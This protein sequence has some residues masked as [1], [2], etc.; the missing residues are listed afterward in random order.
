MFAAAAAE[1]DAD[2]EPFLVGSHG[3]IFS[4]KCV[5]LKGVRRESFQETDRG[6][7]TLPEPGPTLTIS[8][9]EGD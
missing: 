6:G 2:A 3:N 1:E 4:E 5:G 8:S 9:F 7:W